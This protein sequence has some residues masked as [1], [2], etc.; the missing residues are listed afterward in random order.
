[1]VISAARQENSFSCTLTIRD[2]THFKKVTNWLNSH[3]GKGKEHWTCTGKILRKLRYGKPVT[4]QFH[5]AD[6]ETSKQVAS[7]VALL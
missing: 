2:K 3:I 7:F 4:T 5:F 1:M 6:E